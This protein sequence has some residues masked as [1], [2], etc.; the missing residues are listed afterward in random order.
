MQVNFVY[1]V[2]F[3]MKLKRILSMIL[4]AQMILVSAAACGKNEKDPAE[5]KNPS[6]TVKTEETETEE[7]EAKETEAKETEFD[8]ASVPDDL[9]DVTFGGKDF[10]ILAA[11]GDWYNQYIYDEELSGDALNNAL[12]KRNEDVEKRFDVKISP[13]E[14]KG[15]AQDTFM[16]Y[17]WV[18]DDLFDVCDMMMYMSWVPMAYNMS[19][20]WYDI[21]NINWEKP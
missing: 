7:T 2:R 16:Q 10:R 1:N 3:F 19:I 18:G 9:P 5:T 20:N 21:P 17:A 15:E 11:E 8:R 4:A 12:W 13:I 6:E 14:A